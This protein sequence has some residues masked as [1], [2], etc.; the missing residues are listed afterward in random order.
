MGSAPVVAPAPP[1]FLPFLLPLLFC[2]RL[3]LRFLLLLYLLPGL[4]CLGASLLPSTPFPWPVSLA[5]ALGSYLVIRG[6]PVALGSSHFSVTPFLLYLPSVAVR[7]IGSP[8]ICCSSAGSSGFALLPRS[9]LWPWWLRSS[10]WSF[11]CLPPLSGASATPSFLLSQCLVTVLLPLCSWLLVQS[12]PVLR[13]RFLRLLFLTF[14]CLRSRWCLAYIERS[15]VAL[16]PLAGVFSQAPLPPC[17]LFVEFLLLLLLLVVMSLCLGLSVYAL[18]SVA[19]ARS[20]SLLAS[21]LPGSSLLPPRL[22]P[23]SVG[24]VLLGL[25]GSGSYFMAG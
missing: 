10:T 2:L 20:V 12:L 9:P 8:F 24:E 11:F 14:G 18:H 22:P 1:G 23:C 7:C 16:L 25:Y 4:R 6:F 17:S 13:L 19:T 15:L 5:L 3:L 21:G